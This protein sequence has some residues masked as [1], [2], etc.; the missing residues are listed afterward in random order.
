MPPASCGR[1]LESAGLLKYKVCRRWFRWPLRPPKER[2]KAE[3]ANDFPHLLHACAEV[4][5]SPAERPSAEPLRTQAGL[6]AMAR[7]LKARIG[8]IGRVVRTEYLNHFGPCWFQCCREEKTVL[9]LGL[10][11]GLL[12]IQVL[13]FSLGS[14]SVGLVGR[15][16]PKAAKASYSSRNWA[17]GRMGS[18]LVK[19]A[20]A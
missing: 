15:E 14:L 1:A 17:V 3:T 20:S 9:L 12:G 13:A 16:A 18:L 5:S 8:L 6:P 4:S 11:G 10:W 19:N 7:G 2:P